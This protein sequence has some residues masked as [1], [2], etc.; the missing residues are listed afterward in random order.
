AALGVKLDESSQLA[1]FRVV[2]PPRVLG[3]PVFPS[4]LH[5]ALIAL[6]LSVAAGIGA[7]VAAD[8]LGP[9]F[10]DKES[11]RVL[12]GRPVLGSLSMLRTPAALVRHRA[13]VLRF[14]LAF[15][16]LIAAQVAWIIVTAVGPN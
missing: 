15:G 1:E 6:L 7:A 2:E 9:T 8:M 16:L 4:R 3:S 10:D 13:A 14:A 11:L 12:S 5:L